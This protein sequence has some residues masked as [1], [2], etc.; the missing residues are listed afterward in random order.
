MRQA[1]LQVADDIGVLDVLVAVGPVD[2]GAVVRVVVFTGGLADVVAGREEFVVLVGGDPEGLAGEAG[3]LV[4]CAAG[5][6]E[7][8]WAVVVEDFVGDGLLGHLVHAVGV[9][10]IP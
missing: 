6:S 4:D 10:D 8:G 7:E 2:D 9:D 5:L 3:A 1:E